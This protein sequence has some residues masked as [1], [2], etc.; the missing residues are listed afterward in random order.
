MCPKGGPI[1]A[2]ASMTELWEGWGCEEEK[3]GWQ[4][5]VPASTKSATGATVDAG[6]LAA[7]TPGQ[8]LT[9]HAAEPSALNGTT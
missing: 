4:Q 7:Q 3:Q 1:N 6:P 9:S 8:L 2:P 5:T